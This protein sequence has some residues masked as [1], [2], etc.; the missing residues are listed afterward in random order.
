M[1]IPER[2]LTLPVD[3]PVKVKAVATGKEITT[4]ALSELETFPAA[5]LA[6]AYR[7]FDPCEVNV[8][9]TGAEPDQPVAPDK[10]AV[11]DSV[12]IYP[13]TPTSSVA[14]NEEIGIVKIDEVAG[15]T[16]VVTLGAVISVPD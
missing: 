1:K 11:D 5:S 10:G 15:I 14:I 6:Q 12:T 3:G 13:T 16:N 4:L 8:N 9:V 2:L 7:V